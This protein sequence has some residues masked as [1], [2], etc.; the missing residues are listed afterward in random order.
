ML[1]APLQPGWSLTSMYYHTNVAANGSAAVSRQITI[2]Q[3]NP[4][5]N[6]S[7]NEHVHGEAD[8]E[9]LIPSYAFATP[10]AS[11]A[12]LEQRRQ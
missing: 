7:I 10:A 3:F 12:S 2:G 8:I 9:F 1:A 6:V 11:V 5:V 4:T